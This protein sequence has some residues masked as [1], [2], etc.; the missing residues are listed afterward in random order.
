MM[1]S[2]KVYTQHPHGQY[3]KYPENIQQRVPHIKKDKSGRKAQVNPWLA[4]PGLASY[5]PSQ[6]A[7]YVKPHVPFNFPALQ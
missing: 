6:L 4:V 3:D 2:K 5:P 7:M 1:V